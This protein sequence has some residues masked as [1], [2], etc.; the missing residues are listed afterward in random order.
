MNEPV[1]RAG[2]VLWRDIVLAL[3]LKVVLLGVLYMAFF[4]PAHRPSVSTAA[5]LFA[6][7]TEE[8]PKAR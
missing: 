4:T 5:H 7:N 1:H 2:P 6:A 3:T 8:A